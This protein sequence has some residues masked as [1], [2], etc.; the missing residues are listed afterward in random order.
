[1]LLLDDARWQ[2][3]DDSTSLR[4]NIEHNFCDEGDLA[5]PSVW[6]L[7][8]KTVLDGSNL[9]IRDMPDRFISFADNAAA[10]EIFYPPLVLAEF[11]PI[12]LVDDKLHPHEA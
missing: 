4:I 7:A 2:I 6:R 12:G 1:M 8:H 10:N 11:T 3:H 9:N 5:A